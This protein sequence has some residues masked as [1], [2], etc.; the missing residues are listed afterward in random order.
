M[1]N[2]KILQAECSGVYVLK[3]VGEVRLNLCSTIDSSIESITMD[4]NFATIVVD[5]SE[6]TLI[7]STTLGLLAKLAILAKQKNHFMPSI[8]STNPDITRI[9]TTMGFEIVATAGTATWLSD[10]DVDC[11]R[12][13]K[14]YEGRPNIVDMLK[15]G[16]IALVMNTTEGTQ[17]VNDSREIRSVTL[18]DKIPYFTTAAASHAAALAIQA[19]EEG[20]IEVRSL[21]G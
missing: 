8:I 14:V 17:A 16:D 19:R 11:T 4:P 18:M 12:V 2:C 7:D 15:N 9:I 1:S 21:Q 13:N 20:E 5:L 6:T 3:L 10:Q